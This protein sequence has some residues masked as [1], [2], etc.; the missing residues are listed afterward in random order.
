M[1][2]MI[3]F[4]A[5]LVGGE[6]IISQQVLTPT[7]NFSGT[8]TTASLSTTV[9]ADYSIMIIGFHNN[10][11]TG[12][13]EG[14]KNLCNF[15]LSDTQVTI[16]KNNTNVGSYQYVVE[17]IEFSPDIVESNQFLSSSTTSSNGYVDISTSTVNLS[18]KYIVI[19]HGNTTTETNNYL[20]MSD[21]ANMESATSL[22]L[23][24]LYTGSS[25]TKEVRGQVLAFKAGV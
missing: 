2:G 9:D 17:V 3:G 10:T 6:N 11:T 1:S 4:V 24:A 7:A 5:S 21:Y 23:G 13:K 25:Q 12:N 8:S 19:H 16:T 22:R 20:G 15:Q 14:D 18:N